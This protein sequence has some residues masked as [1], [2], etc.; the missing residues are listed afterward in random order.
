[1][2]TDWQ[3]FGGDFLKKYTNCQCDQMAGSFVQY[4]VICNNENLPNGLKNLQYI[5]TFAQN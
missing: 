4:L 5:Q 3:I 1:M 2:W